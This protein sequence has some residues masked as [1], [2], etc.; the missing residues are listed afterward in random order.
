M[1]PTRATGGYRI[2]HKKK[3]EN[4]QKPPA[5]FRCMNTWIHGH[6]KAL[7]QNHR[8]LVIH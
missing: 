5:I 7:E 8:N 4:G 6:D 1:K 2:N 3:K